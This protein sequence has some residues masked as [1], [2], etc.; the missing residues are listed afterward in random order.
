MVKRNPNYW[1]AGRAHFDEVDTI[2][3]GDVVARTN[4]LMTGQID[5]MN[6]CDL[7]TIHLLEKSPNIQITNVPSR[8]HYY[9]AMRTDKAPFNNIDARLAMKYAIDR[10]HVIKTTMGG[11]GTLGND[12]PISPIMPFYASELPQRPYDPDKARY[13]IKK[14]GLEGYTFK[15]HASELPWDQ[16]VDTAL[17]YQQHAAKAGITIEVVREP[18]DGYW[19][20][21]WMQKDFFASR[22]SGRQTEDMM[23][24]QAYSDESNW[25]D[26]YWI[27][28]RFNKLLKAA[29]V[30]LDQAKRRDMYLEMQE[31]IHNDGGTVV[32]AFA[33]LVDA[34]SKKLKFDKLSAQYALDG[35]RCAERWWFA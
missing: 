22:W 21:V 20:T 5:A 11:Y 26:T 13:H 18:K 35:E 34:A 31:I 9:F 25:N 7:K 33:N 32:V 8:R 29:R 27:N 6:E 24:T 15:L 28:E 3:I 19:K 16:A 4:A 14:A 2:A 1:K 17:L 23:L 10:Q 12:H 30:E